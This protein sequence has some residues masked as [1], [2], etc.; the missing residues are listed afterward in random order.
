MAVAGRSGAAGVHPAEDHVRPDVTEI[1]D[2][3]RGTHPAGVTVIDGDGFRGTASVHG[4]TRAA[5]VALRWRLAGPGTV[6]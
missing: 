6:G 1:I 3:A 2:A 4:K 5:P